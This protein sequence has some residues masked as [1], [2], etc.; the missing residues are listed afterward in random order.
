MWAP[1]IVRYGALAVGAVAAYDSFSSQFSFPK[2]GT[3]AGVS[4]SLLPWWGWVL[5]LQAIFVYALFE[6]V[7]R[8]QLPQSYDDT[9]LR[10]KIESE[11]GDVGRQLKALLETVEPA[12]QIQTD[13]NASTKAAIDG[14]AAS[15]ENAL[16]SLDE[17]RTL[18]IKQGVSL[19]EVQAVQREFSK[20]EAWVG[21]LQRTIRFGLQGVDQGFAAILDRERLLKMADDIQDVGD[22][23][24]G[25]TNGETL[26]DQ[27]AW[28]AKHRVWHRT[29]DAWARL[30]ASYRDGVVERVFATPPQEYKGPWKAHD[31]LFPDSDAV[32]DYKT[33][34]IILRNFQVERTVVDCNLNLAAFAH[35]SM[36]VRGAPQ[37]DHAED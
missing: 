30:A 23:L 17:I 26:G 14:T 11:M 34:R 5:I 2:L 28:V 35:P 3:V 15:I 7:R 1:K 29:V 9:S 32:H 12:L 6:Y 20:I 25:P 22:E 21:Q 24:S 16:A 37:T 36:K 27:A 10:D 8:I 19:A 13:I 4:G 33:F 18:T 31:Q